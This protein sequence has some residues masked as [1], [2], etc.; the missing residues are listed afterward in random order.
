[1]E[2]I[3]F[4]YDYFYF[5]KS[6]YNTNP[7][8][9]FSTIRVVITKNFFTESSKTMFEPPALNQS[10]SFPLMAPIQVS[11]HKTHEWNPAVLLSPFVWNR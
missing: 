8:I 3:R 4:F 5:F 11:T 7:K 2:F 6:E 1:M 10:V 9:Y